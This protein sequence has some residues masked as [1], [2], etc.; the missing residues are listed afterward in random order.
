MNATVTYQATSAGEFKELILWAKENGTPVVPAVSSPAA[1]TKGPKELEYIAKTGG[2][3]LRLSEA[4]QASGLTRE[5]VA[6]LRLQG[7]NLEPDGNGAPVVAQL[8]EDD[9]E[10]V[11]G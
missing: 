7:G 8:P 6:E 2:K 1:S 5:Q 11:V 3:R 9:G 4:E 10:D